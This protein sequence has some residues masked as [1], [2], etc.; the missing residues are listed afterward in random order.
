MNER[1]VQAFFKGSVVRNAIK[2]SL[3]VGTLLNLINQGNFLLDQSDIAW[4]Y[5]FSNYMVPYCVA[6]YSAAK[7][8]LDRKGT[9]DRHD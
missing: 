2:V 6:C 7:N 9:D 4:F 1:F 5:I 3:V 8:E